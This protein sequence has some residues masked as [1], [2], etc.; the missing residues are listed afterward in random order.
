M[1]GRVSGPGRYDVSNDA[2]A[3][4]SDGASS[5]LPSGLG[6]AFHVDLGSSVYLH[7]GEVAISNKRV[8]GARVHDRLPRVP[9]ALDDGSS[10]Q[11]DYPA[12]PLAG[13]F[14]NLLPLDMTLV[15][16]QQVK[17]RSRAVTLPMPSVVTPYQSPMGSPL[18]QSRW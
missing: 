5:P 14:L 8:C 10:C 6:S 9:Q 3:S 18:S 17:V 16:Y 4:L 7:R 2:T 12:A 11:P 13:K 15:D 1:F